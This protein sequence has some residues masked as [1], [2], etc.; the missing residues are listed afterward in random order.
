MNRTIYILIGCVI[1]NIIFSLIPFL[2]PRASD[3]ML[4]YQLWF[5]VL[6]IFA[7]IL[8]TEVGNFQILYK[9]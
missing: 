8:P 7:I 9:N 4:P 2:A 5:N 1:I 3:V 6:F